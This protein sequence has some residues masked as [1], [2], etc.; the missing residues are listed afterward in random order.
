MKERGREPGICDLNE[1][2]ERAVNK[3][4]ARFGE[5]ELVVTRKRLP[6]LRADQPSMVV[7]FE[8]II[9]N[10]VRSR[11]QRP[12]RL[13]VSA[14]RAPGEW[15]VH[16]CEGGGFRIK[17]AMA[18]PARTPDPPSCG[19]EGIGMAISRKIVEDLGGRIW[20]ETGPEG[21]P[22]FFISLPD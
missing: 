21:S 10:A 7:V 22:A 6:V 12:A 3:L 2:I 15:V 13:H 18:A 20:A 16:V 9:E 8:K 17:R 1:A 14:S 11:N 4:R 5:R 19:H